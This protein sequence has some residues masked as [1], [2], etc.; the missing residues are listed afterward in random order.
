M[1]IEL[2]VLAKILGKPAS[3]FRAH[4]ILDGNTDSV[5]CLQQFLVLEQGQNRWESISRGAQDRTHMKRFDI[6]LK[7]KLG[8]AFGKLETYVGTPNQ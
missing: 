7:L 5:I 8:G 3:H 2:N 1:N 4:D 6:E